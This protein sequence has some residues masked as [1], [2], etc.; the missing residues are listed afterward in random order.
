MV[1][2]Y[3]LFVTCSMS[4]QSLTEKRVRRR[5]CRYT[6]ATHTHR[7]RALYN[8]NTPYARKQDAAQESQLIKVWYHLRP[9]KFYI[10][11]KLKYIL[12]HIPPTHSTLLFRSFSIS[13]SFC[14]HPFLSPILR[15][16]SSST[17][18]RRHSEQRTHNI[19]WWWYAERMWPFA[20]YCVQVVVCLNRIWMRN[21][22]PTDRLT[23]KFIIA[24]RSLYIFR[25]NLKWRKST[26]SLPFNS[27]H[28]ILVYI[29][30]NT[31]A[32]Q[33]QQ[34]QQRQQIVNSE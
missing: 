30:A 31:V 34:R 22:L 24:I 10:S 17:G 16:S 5:Y 28:G 25:M 1:Q 20:C 7:H 26:A 19:F 2:S 27:R 23:E 9:V 8:S 4:S 11:R 32:Q 29:A 15:K 3:Q 14:V 21:V 12:Y 33:Q 6:V 18:D 13:L